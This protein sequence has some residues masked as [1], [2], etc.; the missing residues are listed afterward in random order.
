MP[1]VVGFE[2]PFRVSSLRV[3]LS[4]TKT[5]PCRLKTISRKLLFLLPHAI[6]K[7]Y[8]CFSLDL[9]LLLK[10]VAQPGCRSF[11]FSPLSRPGQAGLRVVTDFGIRAWSRLSYPQLNY[12]IYYM[13][14]VSDR[15]FNAFRFAVFV[16]VHPEEDG[17]E[18]SSGS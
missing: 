13:I 8:P 3:E 7:I 9:V 10:I 6:S 12:I 18:T 15:A 4:E 5:Q 14:C 11:F 17:A 2:H 16:L 1:G